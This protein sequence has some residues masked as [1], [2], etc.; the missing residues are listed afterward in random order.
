ML[1]TTKE[2]PLGTLIVGKLERS[3]TSSKLAAAVAVLAL[4]C[5]NLVADP[6]AVGAAGHLA[7]GTLA[8]ASLAVYA[9]TVA[10]SLGWRREAN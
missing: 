9:A 6:L 1:F 5:R 10:L 3:S 2:S 7:L 4:L 8:V